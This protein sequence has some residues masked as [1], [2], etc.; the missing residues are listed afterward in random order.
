MSWGYEINYYINCDMVVSFFF[1]HNSLI[2]L[3]MYGKEKYKK[4]SES[5]NARN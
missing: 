1:G 2:V 3:Y 5:K 4:D